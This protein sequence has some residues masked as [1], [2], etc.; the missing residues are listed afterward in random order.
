MFWGIKFE[1][2][3][4]SETSVNI[5]RIQQEVDSY[6]GDRLFILFLIELP[7]VKYYIILSTLLPHL[8]LM[9]FPM[10]NIIFS[11]LHRSVLHTAHWHM[12]LYACGTQEWFIIFTLSSFCLPSTST[13][14]EFLIQVISKSRRGFA[15]WFIVPSC[16]TE[17]IFSYLNTHCVWTGQ[18]RSYP[19]M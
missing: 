4:S 18:R 12:P 5:C 17:V 14:E 2:V 3:D 19:V 11:R 15:L 10:L 9:L 1:A 8:R 13:V 16:L 6:S 7:P